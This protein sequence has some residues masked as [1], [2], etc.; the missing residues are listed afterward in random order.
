[1]VELKRGRATQQNAANYECAD[2]DSPTQRII[3]EELF[4]MPDPDQCALV[5][6]FALTIRTLFD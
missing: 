3:P 1:M 4:E 5:E 6:G 2:I